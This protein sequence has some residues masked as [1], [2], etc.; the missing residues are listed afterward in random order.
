MPDAALLKHEP[1]AQRKGLG[2]SAVASLR[3]TRDRLF[4]PD[5]RPLLFAMAITTGAGT[6]FA[7]PF[8]PNGSGL[9]LLVGGMVLVW[10]VARLRFASSEVASVLLLALAFCLG[11]LAASFRTWSRAAPI[12][13]VES[14]PVLVEGWIA[15]IQAGAKGPRLIIDVHAIGG[16]A[17]EDTPVRVRLTHTKSLQMSSARFVRCW[18]VLRPP[19]AP[20]L[21][22]DYDFRRQAFFEQIGATG[23]V[24]GRC[25]GGTLGRPDNTVS[26]LKL[27]IAATRRQLAETVRTASGDRAGGLAAALISGDRSFMRPEDDEALRLSGLSHIVS[28]SGMHLAIVGGLV[29][30]FLRRS[31]ALIEALALRVPVQ[32]LA[33]VGALLACSVYFIVSGAEVPTQRAFIMAAIVF[34]AIIFD[35]AALSLRTLAIALILVVLVQPESVVAP[36]FQM[37]FAAT[38]AL[39]AAYEAWQARRNASDHR[40]GPIGT[41]LIGLI[42]TSLVAGLATVPYALFHFDRMSSL[43]FIANLLA[44]P[45]ISFVSAPLAGLALVLAPFGW[46]EPALAAFG[47]SL[48]W[49]LA[50]GHITAAHI[51]APGASAQAMP[52]PA[53]IA[54]SAALFLAVAACGIWRLI[55][56][57]AMSAIAVCIWQASPIILMHASASGDLFLR[58]DGDRIERH[59]LYDGDGLAPLRFSN[60]VPTSI[61]KGENGLSRTDGLWQV[62]IQPPVLAANA[63]PSPLITIRDGAGVVLSAYT[64]DDIAAARAITVYTQGSRL[65]EVRARLCGERPW[66]RCRGLQPS[67]IGA[68]E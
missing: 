66:T 40:A 5:G 27:E 47:V 33:A 6:Y 29:F 13:S 43:G 9:L 64:P 21:P 50:I 46:H 56:S 48:E 62:D 61:A 42:I 57:A 41:A 37:S 34:A 26:R 12:V 51:A 44:M 24:L 16:W 30:L 2:Q 19:P 23:Y 18:A 59:Q 22:G 15:D 52:P 10:A 7:L 32:K 36:G 60:L 4:G 8:E 35:R 17:A 67:G 39:I 14:Q 38:A 58:V 63:G 1:L 53:L 45:I 68:D 3:R 65:S 49:V 28:I 11:L 20:G 55:F 25:R 54:F 31:L